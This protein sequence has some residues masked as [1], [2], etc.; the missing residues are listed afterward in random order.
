[1]IR[2][3]LFLGVFGILSSCTQEQTYNQEISVELDKWLER[4]EVFKAR[5]IYESYKEDIS[6][7]KSLIYSSIIANS[8]NASASSNKSITQLLNQYSE[9]IDDTT[10]YDLLKLKLQNHVK[11]FEYKN[12][13]N[14]TS[15]LIESYSPL[16]DS[17]ELSDL[18]NQLNIW[19]A[20]SDQPAQSIQEKQ[21]SIIELVNASRIPTLINGRDEPINLTFDS[22]ANLSVI[23][24]SLAD[25]MGLKRLKSNFTVKGIMGNNITANVAIAEE[26]E[27][28]NV[29][30]ENVVFMVF[31]DSALYFP[32]ADFQIY[33]LLGYPVISALHEIQLT[34]DNKLVI[35]QEST[36]S[37][38]SNLAMN[39]LT[40]VVELVSVQDTLLF[41]FDTGASST[42][43]YEK[44]FNANKKD[45]RKKYELTQLNLGGAGGMVSHDVYKIEF[46]IKIGNQSLTIDSAI[47]FPKKNQVI[48]SEYSGNLGLD[49]IKSFDK[50]ILNFDKMFVQFQ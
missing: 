50:M 25:S 6:P 39:F 5:R 22:G 49:A 15:E 8:F 36:E 18:N 40:P 9:K 42:W 34:K 44:Y 41:T 21:Y 10:K 3:F 30:M 48:H 7:D 29:K 47:L 14:V 45:I 11:L 26:I 20:L 2:A 13:F 43:I 33:G 12:A 46:P 1:M 17:T 24:S 19:K 27:F 38:Y 35:P 28:G 4:N 23:I 37:T 31:P 16:I 32:D